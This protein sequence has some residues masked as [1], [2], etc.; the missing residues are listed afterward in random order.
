MKNKALLVVLSVL[1]AVGLSGCYATV[2]TYPGVGFVDTNCRWETEYDDYGRAY[3]QQYCWHSSYGGYRPY[4]RND[5]YIRRGYVGGPVYYR[6]G[7]N[8]T[9][10]R[11]HYAPAPVIVRPR[12][13]GRHYRGYPAV[14]LKK[15]TVSLELAASKV[16]SVSLE[17][18]AFEST[19]VRTLEVASAQDGKARVEVVVAGVSAKDNDALIEGLKKSFDERHGNV[20]IGEGVDIERAFVKSA[21]V[22]LPAGTRVEI[23]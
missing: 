17:G 5:V 10:R 15:T 9:P 23:R 8:Y 12:P 20:S 1:G 11:R 16:S 7:M 3:E 13:R 18:Q 21:D 22:I 14:N 4:Y 19:Q 2:R 6:P